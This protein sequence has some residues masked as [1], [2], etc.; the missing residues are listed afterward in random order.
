MSIKLMSWAWE[1]SF[2]QTEKMVLLC[3]CDFANDN[4]D[5]WPAV[6]TIA[7]K[8]SVTDRTVQRAIKRLCEWGVLTVGH[9]TGKANQ[10][11]I[12]AT[13]ET[14]SRGH[15]IYRVT[16]PMTGEFYVGA[17]SCE[18]RI[19]DDPYWG[20]GSWVRQ[21]LERGVLLAKDVLEVLPSR[22]ALAKAEE[23]HVATALES[24]L[25]RNRRKASAGSLTPDTVSPRHSVTPKMTT[26][27]PTQCHPTPDTVS[28]KP[29]KNHQ[30]PSVSNKRAR[31]PAGVSD[32]VWSDFQEHRKAKRAPLTASAMSAIEREAAKAGWEIEDALTET[33]LRGW[34]GFKAKWVNDNGRNEKPQAG[35]RNGIADALDREIG[36][37]EPT[38]SPDRRTIGGSAPDRPR[39]LAAPRP[40]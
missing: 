30:E 34:Q 38:G 13:A 27:P 10:Y 20:S 3:L 2:P 16:D 40:G 35:K 1:T 19:E 26:K 37:G 8:C 22:S 7:K 18:C 21:C 31:K 33:M 29:S 32:Q 24:P 28:P 17:R 9:A 11:H 23:G 6:D 4:G 5:C 36:F 12:D 25:C 14:V 39:A 15:Y